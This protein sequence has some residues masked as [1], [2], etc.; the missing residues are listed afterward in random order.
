MTKKEVICVV[1][2]KG[3]R[4]TV[5]VDETGEVNKFEGYA[6]KEGKEYV[7]NEIKDPVRMLTAT[8]IVDSKI[9][10]ALP[11]RLSK[12][13]PKDTVTDCM[14]VIANAR[15]KPPIKVEQVIIPNILDTGADVIAT[16]NLEV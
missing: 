16:M 7:R 1:C 11:V 5:T 12:A 6:C 4:G 3:C 8:V 15:L 2:P 14:N 13:I 10:A 9:R